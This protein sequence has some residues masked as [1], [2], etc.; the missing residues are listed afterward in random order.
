M[1]PRTVP[2]WTVLIATFAISAA[3]AGDETAIDAIEVAAA[4]KYV[5][6]HADAVIMDVRTPAEYE[7]SHITGAINVNVQ[8]DDFET[9]L[10]SLDKDKTYLV[11]CTRNPQNGR[12]SRA[13]EAMQSLGF[14]HLKSL[15]GGYLAWK[16]ADLP[17]TE[18]AN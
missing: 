5:A 4:E 14:K 12:S 15:E 9:M 10:A 11:H 16:E 6:E 18:V 7:M 8:S 3:Q 17:L 1:K 13:L 2:L